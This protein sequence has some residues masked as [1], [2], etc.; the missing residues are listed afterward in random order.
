MRDKRLR[1]P[2]RLGQPP[3]LFKPARHQPLMNQAADMRARL[4]P[5]SHLLLL[6]THYTR[7][8]LNL[9]EI[10]KYSRRSR[11]PMP[12]EHPARWLPS[13]LYPD[14]SSG[15]ADLDWGTLAYQLR[16]LAPREP[17]VQVRLSWW[18]YC[19]VTRT[20]QTCSDCCSS[21]CEESRK[22]TRRT[23][24]AGSGHGSLAPPGRATGLARR[25]WSRSW[26]GSGLEC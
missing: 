11:C 2:C 24:R 20:A 5:S 23:N 3:L 4:N 1:Q 15:L 22:V 25:T 26:I 17:I 21:C 8:I 6:L 19:V 9:D 18:R 16:A 14:R 13:L 10:V 7:M 12:S